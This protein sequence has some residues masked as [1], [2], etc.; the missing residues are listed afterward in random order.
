MPAVVT[1]SREYVCVR[2]QTYED[3][4][5]ADLLLS[6]FRGREGTLENTV[7]CVLAPDAN[8]RLTR[9]G[10]GPAQQFADADAFAAF[11][12]EAF[13]PFAEDAKPLA[14]L[15]LHADLAL[16][17]NVAA[18]DLLPLVVLAADTERQL[19]RLDER[20][21]ALS[22]DDAHVGRQHVVRLVGAEALAAA[23]ADHG[24]ALE[25]GLTLVQPGPYGRTGKVLAAAPL[26]VSAEN[27]ART[28]ER[29]R[30]KHA[31]VAKSRRAHI[32]AAQ[33]EG[34]RWE[35]ELEVTDPGARRASEE[36]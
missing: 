27:L 32:R 25:P 16:G 23:A 4:A 18:C 7:F 6:L 13:A 15:P 24:L 33:R 31:P 35:S 11:L 2:P 20:L 10:R 12:T 8:R 22:W 34:I 14:A 1:A 30:E 21:A 29:G 17:L 3:Q 36:R 5:E 26:S 19:T 9:S 28:L